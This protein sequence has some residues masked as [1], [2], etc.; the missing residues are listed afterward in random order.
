MKREDRI[1]A[2]TGPSQWSLKQKRAMEAQINKGAVQVLL[3]QPG[4]SSAAGCMTLG[5]TRC[6]F[7][8]SPVLGRTVIFEVVDD[9]GN[10]KDSTVDFSDDWV[11]RKLLGQPSLAHQPILAIEHAAHP[12]PSLQPTHPSIS[13][14]H[15]RHSTDVGFGVNGGHVLP[16]I[17]TNPD[18]VERLELPSFAV[19]N[20]IHTPEN[21]SRSPSPLSNFSESHNRLQALHPSLRQGYASS[22][23]HGRSSY[24]TP[25]SS[26]D[27]S[28]NAPSR[29]RVLT[30]EHGL[31]RTAVSMRSTSRQTSTSRTRSHGYPPLLSSH[32]QSHLSLLSRPPSPSSGHQSVV[33]PTS[34]SISPGSAGY[35]Q[36][37]SN[38][39]SPSS[40]SISNQR[41]PSH[42][43]NV[44]GSVVTWDAGIRAWTLKVQHDASYSSLPCPASLICWYRDRDEWEL[45]SLHPEPG[46]IVWSRTLER[47]ELLLSEHDTEMVLVTPSASSCVFPTHFP[48]VAGWCTY[49]SEQLHA[50]TFNV[51]F[52]AQPSL[53]AS[54]CIIVWDRARRV[55]SLLPDPPQSV[56]ISWSLKSR[57]WHF[58][59]AD[60]RRSHSDSPTSS[61]QPALASESSASIVLPPMKSL[62]PSIET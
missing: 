37:S 23:S 51:P 14:D 18:P 61:R 41:F 27:E 3:R 49:D 7:S 45:R 12:H 62:S 1:D 29:G 43:P 6:P 47:W 44:P 8:T 33:T 48:E 36:D 5:L 15:L 53:P 28:L 21:L 57:T 30:L 24:P 19:M 52:D 54:P 35:P 60:S 16:P 59:L 56:D 50:W 46:R 32:H 40:I 13:L 55:W 2:S 20:G 22:Q 10:V 26:H 39:P 58:A 11:R 9:L 31:P 25:L 38:A 17:R 34:P 42:V 4:M